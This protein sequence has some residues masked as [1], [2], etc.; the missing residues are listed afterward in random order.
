MVIGK[1]CNINIIRVL[2]INYKK[3]GLLNVHINELYSSYKEN[4]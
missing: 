4:I 1:Q 3:L 2:Y